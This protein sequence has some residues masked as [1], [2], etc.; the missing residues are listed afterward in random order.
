VAL[1]LLD[2]IVDPPRPEAREAVARC[3]DAGIDVKMITG[4]HAA[5]AASIAADLGISGRAVTGAELDAF[6]D[7]ELQAAIG[8][9]GVCA[10]VSPEQSCG[11]AGAAKGAWWR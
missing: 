1:E 4:D 3:R 11:R 7:D 8:D 5:T 9:I 2:A 10:R 6:S